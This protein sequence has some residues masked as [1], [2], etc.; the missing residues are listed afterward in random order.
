MYIANCISFLRF[1]NNFSVGLNMTS[2]MSSSARGLKIPFI[3][4]FLFASGF[5]LLAQ[6][7]AETTVSFGGNVSLFKIQD[8]G[9]SPA[10]YNGII[11]G[12]QVRLERV[13]SKSISTANFSGE[14]GVLNAIGRRDGK[15][16]RVNQDGFEINYSYSRRLSDDESS[17]RIFAGLQVGSIFR[18]RIHNKLANSARLYEN[19][20]YVGPTVSVYKNVELFG[21]PLTLGGRLHVPTFAAVVR[22]SIT[23]L[24][25]YLVSDENE[26]K[27]RFEEHGFTSFKHLIVVQ[28]AL[29]LNYQLR[30][31]DAVNINY[32]W[33]FIDYNK[34]NSMQS[35]NHLVG[36]S[37]VK[38]LG[39]KVKKGEGN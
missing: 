28:S 18:H 38:L 30:N 32:N 27:S 22:P 2:I 39:G 11:P 33:Q 17:W 16:S 12:L 35:A 15:V 29:S 13:K 8:S 20:N 23:N 5:E 10:Q 26:F 21:L 4:L 19:I 34:P 36:I 31:L 1:E 3:F 14:Q 6:Q 7:N 9:M 25:N 37:Y 24:S